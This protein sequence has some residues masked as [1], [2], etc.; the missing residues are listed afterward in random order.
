MASETSSKFNEESRIKIDILMT[1]LYSTTYANYMEVSYG[2]KKQSITVPS[3]TAT[4]TV[5]ITLSDVTLDDLSTSFYIRKYNSR[6]IGYVDA[7]DVTVTYLT[8]Q[9]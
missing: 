2:D 4:R 7:I 8:S 9:S 3:T 6:H 5:S 1:P